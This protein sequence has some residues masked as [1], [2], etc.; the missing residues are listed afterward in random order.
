MAQPP[1]TPSGAQAR[2]PREARLPVRMS[3]EVSG[4]G[5]LLTSTTENLSRGG[6]CL[7]LDRP[8][9]ENS[10]VRVILFLVEDEVESAGARDLEVAARVRWTAETELGHRVGLEFEALAPAQVATIDRI[11]RLIDKET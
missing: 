1:P 6:V 5:F 11:L 4:H 8:V 3:A 7:S 9:V 10:L 2:V